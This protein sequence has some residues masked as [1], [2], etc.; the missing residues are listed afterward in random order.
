[1]QNDVDDPLTKDELAAALIQTNGG[2]YARNAGISD[3][4]GLNSLQKLDLNS[5]ELVHLPA[6]IAGLSDLQYLDVRNNSI[7]LREEPDFTMHH[8]LLQRVYMYNFDDAAPVLVEAPA[9]N[10]AYVHGDEIEID[11]SFMF[12]D[13][14]DARSTLILLAD[15]PDPQL[16]DVRMDGQ[17]LYITALGTS[18]EP[19]RIELKVTDLLGKVGV[20]HVYVDLR[21]IE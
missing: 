8:T 14:D 5:N 15:S 6:G 20:G 3:V 9:G 2:L 12:E 1:M 16:A 13:E 17:K 4:T 7:P 10:I 21:E 19:I 18:S 11:L